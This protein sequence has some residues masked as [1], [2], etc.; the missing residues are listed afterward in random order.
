MSVLAQNQVKME[1]ISYNDLCSILL[2]VFSSFIHFLLIDILVIL[3]NNPPVFFQNNLVINRH[4]E[5]CCG[6]YTS[7][8][9]FFILSTVY[10]LFLWIFCGSFATKTFFISMQS[11]KFEKRNLNQN[12]HKNYQKIK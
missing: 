3:R 12:I 5:L 9:M 7:M 1:L 6:P 2:K 11:K 8:E 4:Y 10:N